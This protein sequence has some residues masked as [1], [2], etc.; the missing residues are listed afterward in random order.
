MSFMKQSNYKPTKLLVVEAVNHQRRSIRLRRLLPSA[1]LLVTILV[2]SFGCTVA[3]DNDPIEVVASTPADAEP[4]FTKTS[5]PTSTPISTPFPTPTAPVTPTATAVP[6]MATSEPKLTQEPEPT[7]DEPFNWESQQL[8]TLRKDGVYRLDLATEEMEMIVPIVYKEDNWQ[9]SSGRISYDGKKV[10]YWFPEGDEFQVWL[11]EPI[12][13]S[14]QQLLNIANNN[15]TMAYGEWYGQGKFFELGIWGEDEN[16]V[17]LVVQWYLFDTLQ[18]DIVGV[19][20]DRAKVCHTLAVSPRSD[21][22]ATWCSFDSHWEEQSGYVVIEF[23]GEAWQTPEHP[24]HV[25]VESYDLT[26]QY[27]WSLDGN[28]VLIPDGRNATIVNIAEKSTRQLFDERDIYTETFGSRLSPNG[29]LLGYNYH[30]CGTERFCARVMDIESRTVLWESVG[31]FPSPP[32]VAR[33]AHVVA[34]SPDGRF[35][36]AVGYNDA[37]I[38][39]VDDFSVVK[40]LPPDAVMSIGGIRWVEN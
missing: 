14:S 1:L 23:D 10:V 7:P 28:Y 31:L 17:P 32:N 39:Q 24:E 37:L 34:W 12:D 15:F 26:T 18:G 11:V 33:S 8:I 36:V 21:R 22:V 3:V 25:L 30:V 5:L 6:K 40:A 9:L 16:G 29:R 4:V 2:F 27:I 35:F 20:G 13:R 38:I 19:A